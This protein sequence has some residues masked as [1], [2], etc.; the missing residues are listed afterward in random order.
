MKKARFVALC[1][2]A[3]MAAS[4]QNSLVKDAQKSF[5]AGSNYAEWIKTLQQAFNNAESK[6]QAF[7]Y[8][9][10]AKAG[11]ENFD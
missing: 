2:C 1:L 3:G 10:P 11:Y 5:K 4:A 7:T 9:V 6:D 8:L